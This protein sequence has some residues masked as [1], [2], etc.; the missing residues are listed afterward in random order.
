MMEPSPTAAAEK[1]S[2]PREGFDAVVFAGGGCRCFWQA[3]FWSVAAPALALAPQMVG[4]VSAGSAFACAALGGVLDEVVEDFKKRSGR[5]ARNIYPR[6]IFGSEPVFPH[7]R[8]YR[9]T[10]VEHMDDAALERIRSGPDIRIFLARPPRWLGARTAV[11]LGMLAYQLD[12]AVRDQVHPLWARRLGFEGESVSARSCAN[13]DELADLILQS[14]CTPPLMPLYRRDARVVLD[15]GLV[16]AVPVETVG[17]AKNMLVLLSRLHGANTLPRVPGRTYV[18]PSRRPPIE[19]WDYTS[20]A[21]VQQ[22]YDLGRRD[23][24]AFIARRDGRTAAR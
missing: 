19:K 15:G 6:N 1:P 11:V 9:A 24:E 17:E 14:S 3:G 2:V 10:I 7:E 16:D 23:A 8:I 13:G 12:C 21:L 22:T 5:N 20:P 4:A 18:Q